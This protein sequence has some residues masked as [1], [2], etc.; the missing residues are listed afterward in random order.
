MWHCVCGLINFEN[1]RVCV[2]C[3]ANR[4]KLGGF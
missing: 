2:Q 3:G 1:T 4:R